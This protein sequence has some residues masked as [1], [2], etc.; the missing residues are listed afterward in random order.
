[1][2]KWWKKTTR[3]PGAFQWLWSVFVSLV[4]LGLGVWHCDTAVSLIPWAITG[5]LI[6]V[7]G[8]LRALREHADARWDD[9][10]GPIKE[11]LRGQ[12]EGFEPDARPGGEVRWN[13]RVFRARRVEHTVEMGG[14]NHMDFEATRG[15]D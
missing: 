6:I 11:T 9:M 15:G 2:G 14:T 7:V 8:E 5:F 13:G 1:M 12:C 4:I 3:R 10:H